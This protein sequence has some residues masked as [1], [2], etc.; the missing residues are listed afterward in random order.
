MGSVV[1]ILDAAMWSGVFVIC[2]IQAW[3]HEESPVEPMSYVGLTLCACRATLW[4]L[5]G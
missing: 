3:P 5:A 1:T 4:A 2:A